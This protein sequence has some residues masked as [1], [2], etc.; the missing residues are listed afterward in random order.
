MKTLLV[1]SAHPE[2]TEAVRSA[3]PPER[4]R[5]IP[6]L[7]AED[8]EPLL[9]HGL[10]DAC[11]IDAELNKTQPVWLL[12]R[13][14]RRAP[15]LP[16]LVFSS[17]AEGDW[18]EQA[19]LQGATYVLSK[20]LRPRLLSVLLDRCWQ[21]GLSQP[22]T[23][24]SSVSPS[25]APAPAAAADEA[26]T[27]STL[28]DFSSILTHSLNA[29]AMLKQ[30]L[31]LLREVIGVNR[32]A[33]FLRPH[34]AGFAQDPGESRRLRSAASLG[35]PAG[36][37]EHLELSFDSGIG[38]H[39]YRFHRILRRVADEARQ[40]PEAQKEFE[41]LGGQVA[42]PILDRETIIGVAIF[43]GRITGEALGNAE[44]GLIFHLL[45][46]LGLAIKNTWLHD[47]LAANHQMMA[48]ILRELGS[49]CVVIGR[50]LTILH[51]NK[52]AR[53]YFARRE[54]P[55]D[56]EFADLP[57]ELGAK[58]YQVLK[59]GA[60]AGNFRF[61]LPQLDAV[62]NVNIVPFQRQA[63]GAPGSALI[64][65]EDI[66]RGEQLRRL[67]V[68]TANLRL[69]QRMA[70]RLTHE[71]GNAMVPV[72]VHQ[73]LLNEKWKD[74]EFRA[75]LDTVLADTVKRVM[76]LVNQMR[77]LARDPMVAQEPFPVGPVIEEAYQEACKYQPGKASQLR[78]DLPA[79]PLLVQGD[80]AALKH[81]FT[82]VMLNALQANPAEPKIA[83]R[84]NAE[85]NGANR[86]DLQ[87]EVQ[88]NGA[89]FTEETASKAVDPFF[90]TRNVGL[91]LGLAVT[92]KIVETHRG[93][94]EVV[95]PRTGQSGIVRIS[96]PLE[97]PG[98]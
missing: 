65:A 41:L 77:F 93:R 44:L 22:E 1:L 59:T 68:E 87:I 4:Y 37:L 38:G 94:L 34:G 91:G 70:D 14:H 81:A 18:E 58:V 50:D 57:R 39:L 9:V 98:R 30:F 51:A 48:E 13:V 33:I 66:S 7:S 55:G 23:I 84:F 16:I 3:L 61:E 96:L 40:N 95:P 29:E 52:L 32:G 24:L 17:E 86:S 75:S 60:A 46:S 73:Q 2:F 20:P 47:Q 54:R 43:D 90:T 49:A 63:G 97:P 79:S 64:M 78:Y 27:L 56:L 26:K 72:S 53:K 25:P 36:L 67:E 92:R 12:E 82:E 10:A 74:S 83:I 21:T 42:V 80:R 15:R 31:L 76:R 35:I 5:V 8:A 6:G 88:D 69:V 85:K 28:R 19:Y 89:G 71:I 11:L 45:E 62:L